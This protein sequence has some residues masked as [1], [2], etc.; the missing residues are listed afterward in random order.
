M[1]W[2]TWKI[3]ERK[4][5][6]LLAYV[7]LQ[8]FLEGVAAQDAIWTWEM[9]ELAGT[10]VQGEDAHNQCYTIAYNCIQYLAN[11]VSGRSGF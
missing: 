9:G 2:G 7:G 4:E 10:L 8:S 11:L 1:N 3:F 6:V 5:G